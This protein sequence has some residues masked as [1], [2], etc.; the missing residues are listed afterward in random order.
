MKKFVVI[1]IIVLV[2]FCL[3]SC[4]DMPLKKGM[5][6]L[7]PQMDNEIGVLTYDEALTTF[8]P[9]TNT[10][11]GDNIIIATWINQLTAYV[12][13]GNVLIPDTS[14]ETLTLIFNKHTHLLKQWKYTS[15]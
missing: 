12:P 3:C 14:G 13:I 11:F 4:A 10:A 1:V 15:Q 8:G 5:E 9:P 7:A 6:K 2:C